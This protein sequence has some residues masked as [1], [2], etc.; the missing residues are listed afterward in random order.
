MLKFQG[1]IKKEVE[2]LGVFTKTHVEFR[3]VL[4]SDIGISTKEMSH[5]FAEFAEVEACFLRVK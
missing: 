1:S 2:F 4:V 3:W 5:I